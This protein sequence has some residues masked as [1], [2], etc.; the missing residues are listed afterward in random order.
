MNSEIYQEILEQNNKHFNCVI[1]FITDQ[2]QAVLSVSPQ[3]L[4]PGDSVTLSCGVKESSTGWRFF[5]YRTVP[6][7]AGLPSL[8]DKSYSV[9]PLSGNS[10]TL[11]PAGPNHTGGYVCRAGRGDP[12]YHTLY[13]EPQFLWSGD[14]HPSVSLRIRPNRTQHFTSK[15]LSLSCEEKGNSTGW[16]LKRYRER[17]VESGCGSNWGSIAG[18][19]CTIRSTLEKD[20]GVYWC[21]SASGEYSN[22][23]NITVAAGAVILES[24]AYPMTEGDSVTLLCTNRNQETNPNPKVDFYKDGELIRNETTG[25]MT[26]PVVSKSDEGFYKCKSTEGESPES[27][28][29]VRGVTPGPSTLVLVVVV[30]GL[31]VA[32]VLLAILLVLLCRYKNAKCSCCN[33]TFLPPQPQST[34][35]DP[36]QDQGSTKGRVPDAGYT[37]LQHGGANIYDKITLSDN[38]DNDAAAATAGPSDVMY[39]QIQLKKLDK[40]KKKMTADLKYYSEVKTGKATETETPPEADSVYSQVK[41]V[42]APGP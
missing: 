33:R 34:N 7:R 15:S 18:S 13:S 38:N 39:A 21:E 27:W 14:L 30:V 3:W 35:L 31:V 16:R 11:I 20:C 42:T 32:G 40:K 8:L 37:H 28:V 6:Y 26:I 5:W 41:L 36:Q 1:S 17:G 2:P 29:T 24:P 10:Y 12:V 22:A 4:N 19:T 23:V 25:D 9:E